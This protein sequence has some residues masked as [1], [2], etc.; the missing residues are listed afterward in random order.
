MNEQLLY[1]LL[2]MSIFLLLVVATYW[3]HE[4][5]EIQTET[6]RK[7]LHVS[8]GLL[9]LCIP[10]CFTSHWWVLGICALAFILLLV[11][12]LKKWLPAIHRTKRHSIGSVIFPLPVYLCFLVAENY[13]NP[14]LFFLPVSFLTISDSVAEWS[15]KKWGRPSETFSR[16][17]KTGAGSAGFAISSVILSIAWGVFFSL[18]VMQLVVLCFTCTIM[19]TIAELISTHGWDNLTVPL[20]T[21]AVLLTLDL[22]ILD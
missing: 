9:A 18:P 17:G 15:G 11:T 2:F 5:F 16:N 21:V 4:R 19:A 7:F 20:V 10:L 3:L 13:N 22:V 6:T 1:F 14:L 8:G 12:Y